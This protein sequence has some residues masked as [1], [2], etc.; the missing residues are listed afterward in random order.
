MIGDHPGARVLVSA[1]AGPEGSRSEGADLTERRA[2][3]VRTHLVEVGGVSPFLVTA[4]GDGWTTGAD[5]D[6]RRSRGARVEV[7]LHGVP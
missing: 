6:P 4:H 3:A 2:Q 7:T 1:H 5:G